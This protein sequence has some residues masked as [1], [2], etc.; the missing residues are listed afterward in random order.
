MKSNVSR[1]KKTACI[2]E[3]LCSCVCCLRAFFDWRVL[4]LKSIVSLIFLL[5]KVAVITIFS[6]YFIH[7]FFLLIL[8]HWNTSIW[9]ILA[10]LFVDSPC[11][12][13]NFSPSLC[14]YIQIF[15][16]LFTLLLLFEVSF[17]GVMIDNVYIYF[18][19]PSCNYRSSLSVKS[20]LHCN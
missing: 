11:L 10:R 16:F 13:T 17:F 2:Y 7:C 19:Y 20:P 6:Q 1:K 14:F 15:P 5:P 12:F 9:F 18:Q 4:W 3:W 8:E